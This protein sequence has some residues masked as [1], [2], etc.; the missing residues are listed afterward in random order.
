VRLARTIPLVLAVAACSTQAVTGSPLGEPDGGSSGGSSGSSGGSSGSSGGSSGSSSGSSGNDAALPPGSDGGGNDGASSG[1][2][3]SGGDSGGP[4]TRLLPLAVGRSW[5]YDVA[6][7]GTSICQAG[8]FDIIVGPTQQVDG[9]T[10]FAVS[11]FCSG[12]GSTFETVNGDEVDVDYQTTWLHY[13]DV[14]VQDG[15][16]WPYFNTSY[17]WVSVPT[18]TVPA[19][20]FTGCWKASQ[21]VTYTAYQTF[22]RGVGMVESYSQDLAGGG[23]DAKLTKKSF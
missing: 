6:T 14:P 3:S 4:D 17:T 8:S 10:A 12:V 15:H 22:C 5:T 11:S 13:L 20:T 16:T 23:W 21:N 18:I 19:G 1:D 9:R 7:F 2:G